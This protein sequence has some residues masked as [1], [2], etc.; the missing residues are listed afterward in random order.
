MSIKSLFLK[1]ALLLVVLIEPVNAALNLEITGGLNAGRKIAIVPFIGQEIMPSD[2]TAIIKSD[3][4]NSGKFLPVVYN[5]VNVDPNALEAI[6]PAQF[7]ADVEAVVVGRVTK[8]PTSKEQYNVRFLLIELSQG[9]ARAVSG[10]N[11]I[12]P[13]RLTRRYAHTVSD[14]VFEKMTGIKG[15]F[16]T[17]IAYIKTKFGTKHPYELTVADY[18]GS[19]EVR[20]IVSS[21]PLMSPSWSPDGRK[22]AYVSFENRRA[23]IF[24]IDI[25][26]RKR[27]KVTSFRGLNSNPKWSPDGQKLAFVLSKDGNPEIYVLN[28]VTKKLSRV[29]NNRAIDTEPAWTAN[30]KELYFV[31]ERSGRAQIYHIDLT[32]GA[33]KKV[34]YQ[35]AKNLSPA[36]MPDNNGI[37]MINQS[38]GFK[39]AKF[40]NY[41][42]LTLLTQSSLDESPSIA[43]NGTMVIYSTIYGGKKGLALVSTDGRFKA[44]LPNRT[45]E[46]SS[47]SWSPYLK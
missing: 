29:T 10:L 27:T 3:L 20:L 11:S 44:Y 32:N 36:A 31:S 21:Q 4:A 42:N 16:N 26:T 37:V 46:I 22:L 25:N 19:N 40:D 15:A 2:I 24:I 12:V 14:E 28:L 47:P 13:K 39:V 7:P 33:T 43:P 8:A 17:R 5:N 18:D 41:G 1:V 23:E 35:G 38:N 9:K 34:T 6:N 30:S 45:G